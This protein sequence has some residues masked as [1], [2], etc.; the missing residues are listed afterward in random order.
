MSKPKIIAKLRKLLARAKDQSDT[1]EGVLAATI[2]ARLMKEHAISIADL[3]E[4][5]IVEEVLHLEWETEVKNV[6]WAVLYQSVGKYTDVAT[7]YA[8]VRRTRYITFVGYSHN[9]E[10]C[11]FLFDSIKNQLENDYKKY[12]ADVRKR[13]KELGLSYRSNKPKP[14][15]FYMSAIVQVRNKLETLKREHDTVST[16]ESLT[17]DSVAKANGLIYRR[18]NEVSKYVSTLGWRTHRA[19]KYGHSSSGANAGKNVRV[20]AGITGFKKLND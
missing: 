12:C 2:A 3:D 16:Q 20:Q 5:E 15:P 13:C 9:I 4:H 7:A 6:W 18:K 11:K 8:S 10:I 1:P 14:K 19:Y 17:N